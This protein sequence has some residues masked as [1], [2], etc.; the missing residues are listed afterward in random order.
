M[1]CFLCQWS[2][3][4]VGSN[5]EMNKEF[6]SVIEKEFEMTDLGHMKYFLELEVKQLKTD[7]FVSQERY[8]EEILRKFSWAAPRDFQIFPNRTLEQR[9]V[10][11]LHTN[12]LTIAI[13]MNSC[14]QASLD[15]DHKY[16]VLTCRF[17]FINNKKRNYFLYQL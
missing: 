8:A 13:Y 15:R 11:F 7:I 17:V 14:S 2:Y 16:D 1:H 12:I 6:E 9:H 3:L 4:H 10:F 5:V